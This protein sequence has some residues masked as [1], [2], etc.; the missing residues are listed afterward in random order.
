MTAILILLLLGVSN[1]WAEDVA[2]DAV[3]YMDNSAANWTYSN[4]YFVINSNGYPMSAVDHTKLYVH[5]RIDNTW[6]S[7]SS[8]R[9]FAATSSWGGNNASLGSESNMS[10]YGA[11]LTNTITKYGFG[12]EY[13]VIKLD[14]AGTKTNSSTRANLSASWIGK[15]YT[16][17]NKTITVKAKVSTDGGT[18]YEEATSP[19]TLSASSFRFSSYNTCGTET[20]LNSGTIT[21]GYTANTTLVAVAATGYTFAGWYDDSGNNQTEELTLSLNPT[22]DATY[23][24]YY[25][26]NQYTVKFDANGG[27]GGSMSNQSHT[28]GVSKA[29]TANA[30]TRTGYTFAG[31]NTKADGTGTKYTDKQSVSNLSSTDGATITLYA[32]WE[33]ATYTIKYDNL[34]GA[35][36]TNPATYTINSATITFT[37]PTSKP[38]GYTFVNWTP[39]SI[40]KGSY[41]DKTVTANWTASTSTVTLNQEEATTQGTASV[42]ATYGSA[43]PAITK[44]SRTGYTFGGYFTGKDGAGTKYYNADGSSATTWALEGAQT[45]Y[46]K[47]EIINYTI[48]YNNT[49]DV[50]ISDEFSPYLFL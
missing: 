32:Q 24:A 2:K 28:Y 49:Y 10:S 40:E 34:K 11:N 26:A 7:Y 14:K 44:P 27:T 30:F 17:L 43:M 35:T 37:A 3:I 13:Y 46:A 16:D 47:W 31:W 15:A 23:Y 4:I 41:D 20:S 5:K 29:L 8:V 25:K 19:G 9:F 45:L 48:T 39:A 33:L 12:A 18:S 50:T 38:A 22:A 1:A 6:G 42:T 21:C 36:H